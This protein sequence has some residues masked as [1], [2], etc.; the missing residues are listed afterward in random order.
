MCY[1]ELGKRWTQFFEKQR[2]PINDFL[3]QKWPGVRFCDPIELFMKNEDHGFSHS[4]A[5]FL[6][7]SEIAALTG[8]PVNMFVIATL[9]FLHDFARFFV[10][11][12]SE[13]QAQ[14]IEKETQRLHPQYGQELVW[15]LDFSNFGS[16]SEAIKDQIAKGIGLH[17]IFHR[18]FLEKYPQL[19][20]D[21]NQISIFRLA[22]KTFLTPA[23]EARRGIE[24]GKRRGTPFFLPD[25][26]L[27]ERLEAN[28]EKTYA[29]DE[30]TFLLIVLGISPEDFFVEPLMEIYR[31]WEKGKPEAIEVILQ[32][33]VSQ[34]ADPDEV[35]SVIDTYLE[36]V[37][38]T[39]RASL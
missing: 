30:L 29:L 3:A 4:L 14:S 11:D 21:C 13:K 6:R 10:P 25:L 2:Q 15:Q 5:V 16:I 8:C 39:A 28:L 22:D 26:S 34:G 31:R 9:S 7:A 24:T 12:P 18:R 1:S 23:D 33:A 27:K 32:E 19:L 20:L 35:R 38:K 37:K 36:A 17:D